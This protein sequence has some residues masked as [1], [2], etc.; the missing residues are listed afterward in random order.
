MRSK[1]TDPVRSFASGRTGILIL[2]LAGLGVVIFGIRRR[3]RRGRQA[4]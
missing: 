2:V 3:S 1:V 4:T